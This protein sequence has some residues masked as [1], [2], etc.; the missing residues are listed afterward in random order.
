MKTEEAIRAIECNMPTSGYII[1][2]EALDIAINA[3]RAQQEAEKNEPL[4]MDE[5]REMD[6]EPVWCVD[7]SGNE[8]WGLVDANYDHVDVID[9][10]SGLWDGAF[11]NMT[12]AWENGLHP[13]GWL[14]Y[15][16]KPKEDA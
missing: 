12:G 1:L 5:L 15:R 3:L 2:R 10:Q 4:T 7:G 13:I 16:H 9:C 14:A 6:G 11:Y 8:M